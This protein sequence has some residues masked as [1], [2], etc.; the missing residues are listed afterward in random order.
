MGSNEYMG[1]R[2]L[3]RRV[4][5]LI[6]VSASIGSISPDLDH[7]TSIILQNKELWSIL[8]QPNVTQFFIWLSVASLVG[9]VA[10]LVLR[11]RSK[12]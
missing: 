7:F 11:I 8:H 5:F 3:L 12:P 6:W 1:R 4:A 9:L 2:S 10:G